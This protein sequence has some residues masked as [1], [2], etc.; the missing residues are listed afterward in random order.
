[1]KKMLAEWRILR[2]EYGW[3]AIA[4]AM[5]GGFLFTS[6]IF[7]PV[8]LAL[9]QFIVIYMY[10]KEL[11]F[12]LIVVAMMGF[13]FSLNMM[14][15]KSLILKKPDHQSDVRR[16]ML[17]HALGDMGFLFVAGIVFV[18]IILPLIWV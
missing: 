6:L 16:V 14:A 15:A 3:K 1:M 9:A 7:L 4:D 13:A 11:W 8:F 12:S 2:Q 5:M 10:L 17:V 18:V